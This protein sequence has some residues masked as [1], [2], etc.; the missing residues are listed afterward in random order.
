[1]L[2]HCKRGE[3]PEGGTTCNFTADNRGR[4][5]VQ[6]LSLWPYLGQF[7]LYDFFDLGPAGIMDTA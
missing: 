1:M 3:G 6:Q 7:D 2:I 4:V 5:G